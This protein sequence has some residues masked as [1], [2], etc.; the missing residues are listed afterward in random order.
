M[1]NPFKEVNWKPDV[2]ERRAFARSLIIGFPCVAVVLFLVFS[3]RSGVWNPEKPL[4]VGGVGLGVGTLLYLVPA[5]AKPFYLVWYAAACS[6]GL[7]VS[8]LLLAIVYY[9]VVTVIGVLKRAT[10]RRAIRKKVDKSAPT[11]WVDVER[12]SSPDRYF[13]QF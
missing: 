7:V 4:W 11:Y 13:S 9:F 12:P 2:A 6:I 10:G 5:V 3:W 8:N 1:V